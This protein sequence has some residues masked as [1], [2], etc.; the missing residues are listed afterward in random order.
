M[1][2][3]ALGTP[4]DVP[5]ELLSLLH[6]GAAWPATLEEPYS[7]VCTSAAQGALPCPTPTVQGDK[8]CKTGLVQQT[9]ASHT[10]AH[11]PLLFHE[12]FGLASSS[13]SNNLLRQIQG[14][15]TPLELLQQ[16]TR[17]SSVQSADS[18]HTGIGVDAAEGTG[19]CRDQQR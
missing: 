15:P 19:D 14:L 11:A 8:P 12:D 17:S 7:T 3:L 6:C 4:P 13:S 9:L 5:A 16:F 1:R 18:T 10:S 2:P